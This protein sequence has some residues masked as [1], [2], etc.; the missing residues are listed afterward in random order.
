M[1]LSLTNRQGKIL[2]LLHSGFTTR[3]VVIRLKISDSILQKEWRA[4]RTHVQI[5]IPETTDDYRTVAM[6]ERVERMDLEA[7]S[8]AAEAR[9]RALMDI[10]PEAVLVI[11]GRTGVITK[12]NNRAFILLGYSP[13]ELLHKTMEMLVD[14][15]LRSK[16]AAL[17][18]GFLNSVRKRELGFHPPIYALTKDGRYIELD[19]ALTTT[20][21]TDDVM[22]VCREVVADEESVL[23]INY[24]LDSSF[25]R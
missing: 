4:I 1:A 5:S 24:E 13:R 9:L 18:N 23:G 16:H 22:V 3:D 25:G 19:I 14:P 7:E 21:A 17:R 20:N 11:N 10:S 15:D 8:C 2:A 6:F 12:A